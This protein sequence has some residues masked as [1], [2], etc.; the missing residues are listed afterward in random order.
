MSIVLKWFDKISKQA[1]T[2]AIIAASGIGF[3][4]TVASITGYTLNDITHSF[5][6]SLFVIAIVFI[7]LCLGVYLLIGK[8]YK[9][10][11]KTK[12]KNIPVEITV[13]DIFKADGFKVIGFDTHFDTRIDDVVISK[14]SLH[15]QL[16]LKHGKKEE[17]EAIVANKAKLLGLQKNENGLFDFPLGTIIRYDS[18]VDSQ[19]YLLLALTENKYENGQY[20]AYTS[21]L[22]FEHT[23]VKMWNEIDGVYSYHD[24]VLPLLG[25]GISRFQGG[26]K[27]K[28]SILRCML[29][30]LNNSGVDLSSKVT[31]VIY[32]DTNE[33]PLYEFKNMFTSIPSK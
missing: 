10:S 1:K 7:V 20:K 22:D 13:G 33:V 5:L 12:I 24:I 29:C 30:T 3:I 15:G 8:I 23:L 6:W 11:V 16:V 26:G 2:S 4:A 19:T 9:N 28:E 31:I 18:S 21:M 14:A 25:T 27:N 17:I 32:G